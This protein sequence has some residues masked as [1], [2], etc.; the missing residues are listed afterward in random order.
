MNNIVLSLAGPH[1]LESL[2]EIFERKIQDCERVGHT[3]W[4]YRSFRCTKELYNKFKPVEV[5]F[6]AGST[7]TS[8]K[9]LFNKQSPY[10]VYPLD[11]IDDDLLDHIG[12]VHLELANALMKD[13]FE[14]DRQKLK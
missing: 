12:K 7:K 4:L 10:A 14:N 13:A 2:S 5:L 6:V 3:F 9:L 1:A 11:M 8:A